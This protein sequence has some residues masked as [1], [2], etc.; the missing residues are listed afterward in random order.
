MVIN[1]L[2]EVYMKTKK[3]KLIYLTIFALASCNK[4]QQNQVKQIEA[5]NDCSMIFSSN[6]DIISPPEDLYDSGQMQDENSVIKLASACKILKVKLDKKSDC[7]IA[8]SDK[9]AN[10]TNYLNQPNDNSI[11]LIAPL[12]TLLEGGF[13]SYKHLLLQYGIKMNLKK[14]IDSDLFKPISDYN[15]KGLSCEIEGRKITIWAGEKQAIGVLEDNK[16][17][18]DKKS[19][20]DSKKLSIKKSPKK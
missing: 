12:E 4:N 15:Y 18:D 17:I 8:G 16:K 6:S 2:S 3:T 11:A 1:K 7:Q 10:L 9:I 19:D 5:D 13:L 20:S 14:H